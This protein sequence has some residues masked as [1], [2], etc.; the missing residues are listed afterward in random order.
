MTQEDWNNYRN[1][2]KCWICTERFNNHEVISAK[3][4]AF[5]PEG[6]AIDHDHLRGKIA[7]Y[8]YISTICQNV[9]STCF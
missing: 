4:N 3:G 7:S 1:S 6:K 8:Q 9:I 2:D 5:K